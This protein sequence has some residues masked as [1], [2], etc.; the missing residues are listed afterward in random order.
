MDI[1]SISDR[2]PSRREVMPSS[3]HVSLNDPKEQEDRRISDPSLEAVLIQCVAFDLDGVLI[4]SGPSFDYFKTT[5]NITPADF[6]EF[7]QGSYELAMSGRSDLF[8]ILPA[9]LQKWKWAGTTEEF[10]RIWFDSCADAD[11]AALQ[12]VKTLRDRGVA[13]YLATNQDNRR[14]AYLDSLPCLAGLFERRFY[15][16]HL[17]A[18]KPN[19]EYFEAITHQAALPPESIL[20]VDDK[21]SNVEGARRCGWSAEVCTGAADLRRVMAEYFPY[22]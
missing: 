4:P 1:N 22:S 2:I 16:C 10:A 17:G 6:G 9:T 11:P 20:F 13:C 15:S 19:K 5:H 3:H 21:I 12:L 14:A 7:F 18:M 8:E